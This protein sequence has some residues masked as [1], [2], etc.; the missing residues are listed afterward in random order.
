MD[1]GE[2]WTTQGPCSTSHVCA[3]W[4]VRA[5]VC[6]RVCGPCLS[7]WCVRARVC[8]RVCGP[9]PSEGTWRA[10][11]ETDPG[12]CGEGRPAAQGR[13][14]RRE[15]AHGNPGSHFPHPE[16]GQEPRVPRTGSP[17]SNHCGLRCRGRGPTPRTVAP[18]LPPSSWVTWSELLPVSAPWMSHL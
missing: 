3:K 9:C 2:G 11:V 7:K 10:Q 17:V 8:A 6:A 5:H 4:C 13:S 18:P 12:E 15:A 1:S 16:T 14:P